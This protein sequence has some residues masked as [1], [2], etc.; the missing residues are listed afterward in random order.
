[1]L[2]QQLVNGLALGGVYALITI[3]YSL[4][5]SILGLMNFAHGDVY[6]FGTMLAGMLLL[7]QQMPMV[8]ALLIGIVVGAVV[9]LLVE[10]VAYRPLRYADRSISMITAVGAALIL[11]NMA[12]YLWVSKTHP[13][14][15]I[16]GTTYF[17]I[18]N[19]RVSLL[20]LGTLVIS[21]ALIAGLNLFLR[22]TKLGKAILFVAQDIPTSSLMGIPINKTIVL[23]YALGGM[24]GVCGGILYGS[25]YNAVYPWMGFAG[26][27]KAFTAAVVGGLGNLTGA[28]VGGLILG[29][30]EAL[31]AA[32]IS[33]AYRDA[34]SFSILI[35]VLLIRP[36]GIFGSQTAEQERV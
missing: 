5:Y 6:M 21:F 12:E 23:V 28:L 7:R 13:F 29:V 35:L 14:P 9:G 30:I 25:I 31:A 18:S 20:Q 3:G 32:Y 10:R 26:T 27:M 11:R 4:V 34:I 2:A 36:S 1:M 24:L 16:F 22:H 8:P 17:T 15:S 19:V 33:S